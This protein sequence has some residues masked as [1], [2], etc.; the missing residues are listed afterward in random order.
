MP[1]LDN[2][3]Q[4]ALSVAQ[5]DHAGES[6]EYGTYLFYQEKQNM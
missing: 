1:T 2:T 4:R 5:I 6:T 3:L